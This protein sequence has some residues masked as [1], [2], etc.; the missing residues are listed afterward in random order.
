MTLRVEQKDETTT[1]AIVGQLLMGNRGEFMERIQREIDHG[2]RRFVVDLRETGYIDSSGLGALVSAAKKVR[3]LGGELWV[4]NLNH[5]IR[6][7][8]ELTKLDM[9]LFEPP[10]GDRPG[11]AGARQV[12]PP[13][14]PIQAS[15]DFPRDDRRQL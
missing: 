11:G 6:T 14:P 13:P 3:T 2:R 10:D 9:I 8:F 1:I 12:A 5:D 15:V 4:T 7:L